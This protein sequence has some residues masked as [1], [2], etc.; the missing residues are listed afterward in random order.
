MK[1]FS[2]FYLSNTDLVVRLRSTGLFS[3]VDEATLYE[4]AAAVEWIFLFPNETLFRQGEI[5]DGLYIVINGRLR[6][7]VESEGGGEEFIAEL[8]R[9]EMVGEMSLLTKEP[10]SATVRAI[11]DTHLVTLSVEAYHHVVEKNP[12]VMINVAKIIAKRLGESQKRLGERNR[13]RAGTPLCNIAVVPTSQNLPLTDFTTRLAAALNTFGATLHLSSRRFETTWGRGSDQ[14]NP[15]AITPNQM[16]DWLN[17]QEDKFKF[18]LFESDPQ[19]TEWTKRCIRRA[20]HILIL[21]QEGRDPARGQIEEALLRR[22][23]ETSFVQQ[24]LI[25][26]HPNGS[27]RPTQTLPWLASRQV[28]RHYH[29][30]WDSNSDFERLARTLNGRAIG[31]V[32]GGGGARGFAHIGVI[33]ALKE[34]NIP[35]DFVCG[36][37]SGATFAAQFAFEFDYETMIKLTKLHYRSLLDYTL[38]ITALFAGRRAARGLAKEFGATQIEDLWV[39]FFCV[40]SNLTSAKIKIHRTGS[41]W[42]SLRASTSLPGIFPPVPDEGDLLVDGGLLNNLPID[43]MTRFCQDGLVIA[44]DVGLQEDLANNP[45]YGASLSGWETLWSR[46]NPLQPTIKVPNIGSILNRASELATIHSRREMLD[47]WGTTIA[48]YLDP[49]VGKFGTLQFDPKAIDDLADLGYRYTMQKLE[50]W[51]RVRAN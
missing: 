26:I 39:P 47:R 35:V 27:Q 23:A 28:E 38:P 37:S 33:R 50:E 31:L 40:S 36:T 5:E 8:G 30:R 13:L 32:L 9:G 1:N 45:P 22:G 48:L 41:L 21:G 15:E 51:H 7:L 25:L 18:I 4:I 10:R 34:A 11:R 24:T 43:E 6:V 19:V 17:D 12:R 14:E 46:I 29:L 3:E 20:D 49:P 42:R 44:V 2:P 16:D